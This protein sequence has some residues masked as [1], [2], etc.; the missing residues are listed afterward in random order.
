MVLHAHRR[1]ILIE[2]THHRQTHLPCSAADLEIVSHLSFTCGECELHSAPAQLSRDSAMRSCRR[3]TSA[4]MNARNFSA[5]SGS[6]WDSSSSTRSRATCRAYRDSS[7]GGRP[8]SALSSPTRSV[9]LKRSARRWTR[10]ASMLSMLPRSSC[11][12]STA[13]VLSYLFSSTHPV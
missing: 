13:R 7:A 11:S 6:R 5:N 1:S 3:M 4:T 8:W 9:S 10:E 2:R 12:H